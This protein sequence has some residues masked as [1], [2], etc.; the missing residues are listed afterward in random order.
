MLCEVC[1]LIYVQSG[2]VCTGCRVRKHRGSVVAG[3]QCQAPGCGIAHPR[4]LR[5]VRFG[6]ATLVLC[7]NHAALAGRRGLDASEFLGEL[8]LPVGDRRRRWERRAQLDRRFL[9]ERRQYAEPVEPDARQG[10]RRRAG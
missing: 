2:T 6:D 3:E 4:V 10:E 5:R 7:A 8:A 9:V 1:R